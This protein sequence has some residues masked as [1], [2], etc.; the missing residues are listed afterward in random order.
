M[1]RMHSF[2]YIHIIRSD[3]SSSYFYFFTTK[4]LT[5]EKM[6]KPDWM[7]V[8]VKKNKTCQLA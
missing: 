2:I 5:K 7:I 1:A 8:Q 6:M 3:I 4:N